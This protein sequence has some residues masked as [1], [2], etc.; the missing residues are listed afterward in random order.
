V[1][2]WIFEV[3]KGYA[4]R[5][6]TYQTRVLLNLVYFVILGPFAG[7]GRLFGAKL[8]D[9]SPN[10]GTTWLERARSENT[11]PALRRQF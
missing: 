6:A 5:A 11:L 2:G 7:L 8:M 1:L 3:W 4:H 9:V 10:A